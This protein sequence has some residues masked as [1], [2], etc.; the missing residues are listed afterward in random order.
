[1]LQQRFPECLSLRQALRFLSAT[2]WTIPNTI[3]ETLPYAEAGAVVTMYS[4]DGGI[5]DLA[6]ANNAE[7]SIAYKKFRKAGAGTVN[8]RTALAFA[9]AKVPV[10]DPKK[11]VVAGHSSA[12]T[13]S[14]LVAAHELRVAAAIAYCPC[15][16]VQTRMVDFV[17]PVRGNPLFPDVEIIFQKSFPKTQAAKIKCPVFLF[18]AIDDSNCPYAE[19]QQFLELPKSSGKDA[20]LSEPAAFG[21]HYQPMIDE[22][23]PRAIVWLRSR[24]IFSPQ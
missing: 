11:I 5:V 15:T 24:G 17:N 12:G 18:H 6:A 16:D 19:S 3:A 23:V 21:D 14:L 4:L 13:E 9:L 2:G 7:L 1:M 8:V 22:G 20:T 10:A